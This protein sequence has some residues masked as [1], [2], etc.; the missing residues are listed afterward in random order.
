MAEWRVGGG[1]AGGGGNDLRRAGRRAGGRLGGQS[2]GQAGR[3]AG[4]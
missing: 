4:G 3:W 1:L 2:G